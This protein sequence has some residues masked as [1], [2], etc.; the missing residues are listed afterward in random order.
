MCLCVR[1]GVGERE[2][3]SVCVCVCV[4]VCVGVRA[5]IYTLLWYP[6]VLSEIASYLTKSTN[7]QFTKLHKNFLRTLLCIS[8]IVL[9]KS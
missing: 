7:Y 8:Y 3:V 2:R 4:C 9:S 5:C 1:V 6:K